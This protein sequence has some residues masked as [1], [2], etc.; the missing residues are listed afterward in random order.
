MSTTDPDAVRAT[1]RDDVVAAV[2]QT[3]IADDPPVWED[4]VVLAHQ[5]G[6][7]PQEHAVAQLWM[8]LGVLR[9]CMTRA[10]MTAI[11]A[12]ELQLQLGRDL[13]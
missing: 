1:F 2:V 7:T 13:P 5:L 6:A 12:V 4:R 9:S 3:L 10:E 8:V 11:V